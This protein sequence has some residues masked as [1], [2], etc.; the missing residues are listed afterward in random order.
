M[1]RDRSAKDGTGGGPTPEQLAQGLA[2]AQAD[3]LELLES[4]RRLRAAGHRKDYLLAL[5]AHD[6]R[7]PL[8]VLMGQARVLLSG[9]R[10]ALAEPQRKSV[11]AIQR[12]G[13]RLLDLADD[14]A[15]L[16]T[17]TLGRPGAEREPVELG[18]LCREVADAAAPALRDAGASLARALPD[19]P[20]VLRLEAEKLR[21]ALVQL[22]SHAIPLATGNRRLELSL[23]PVPE[24]ARISLAL[25]NTAGWPRAARLGPG[26]DSELGLAISRELVELNGGSLE[27]EFVGR[28]QRF[29]VTLP[30]ARQ[31]ARGAEPAPRQPGRP[32][33]LVVDDDD[34]QRESLAELLELDYQVASAGGGEEGVRLASADPPD[35]VLMDLVMPHMDGFAALE[36]LHG[37]RRT[38][39]VPVI[40]LSARSD[41]AT[42]VKGLDLGAVDFLAKPFSERELRAR[43]E[44]TLRLSRRQT[45][46]HQLAETDTLTG[47]ANLRAF[48][49][50]L[51]DEVRRAQ[52]YGMPLTC[53]MSDVDRL[54]SVNDDL[55]HAAGDRVIAVTADV[56]RAEMRETDF[57]ARYGGDEFVMLLPHTTV[58]EGGVL[59]QRV[60]DRLGAT[61]LEVAGRHLVLAASFGVAEL[62]PGEADEAADD[63]VRRADEA[64][65]AAK[66]AGRNRVAVASPT[67]P[68]AGAPSGA[69]LSP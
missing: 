11:E 61:A 41:D 35:L 39:E 14:L 38:A 49:A 9:A 30:G 64:L 13:R 31:A 63:L 22:L 21:R 6:L 18:A 45:Q 55:G 42:R 36:A 3:C 5:C 4:N 1:A 40:F 57:A 68:G 29:V 69:V 2:R 60:S 48:R 46:L 65:Y 26:T 12:Q 25:G 28:S 58:A 27:I 53:I 54:K 47:L 67:P 62:E 17:L 56:V 20:L 10:G 19:R 8:D 16:E 50:R 52:R 51:E 32:R 24:G 66:R 34:D 37:D 43:I 15:G 7:Q 23:E 44:R 59:A 33:L